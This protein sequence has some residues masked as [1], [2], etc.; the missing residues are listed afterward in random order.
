MEM[1]FITRKKFYT[2][3]AIILLVLI[4]ASQLLANG[5]IKGLV[6]DRATRQPLPGANIRVLETSLGAVSGFDGRFVI[7]QISD[8]MYAVEATLLGYQAQRIENK[9]I[10]AGAALEVNFELTEVAIPLNE[11]IVTP[12]HFTIMQNEPAVRQALT[13]EEIQAIPHFGEDIYRAVQRLPGISGNDFSAKFT[14]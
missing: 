5:S 1:V 10:I 7:A 14:V 6:L 2:A 12:G 11:I 9:F 3:A 8:G 4:F 13:R